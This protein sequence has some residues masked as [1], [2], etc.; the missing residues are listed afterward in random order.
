M[1]AAWKYQTRF[2]RWDGKEIPYMLVERQRKGEKKMGRKKFENP[3]FSSLQRVKIVLYYLGVKMQ[4]DAPYLRFG[5]TALAT[6]KGNTRPL[7]R[8]RGKN[9]RKVETHNDS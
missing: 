8:S 2:R 6:V 9:F 4:K 5:E 1:S 3:V 7:R